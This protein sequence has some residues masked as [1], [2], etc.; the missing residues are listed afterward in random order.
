[1]GG[2]KSEWIYNYRNKKEVGGQSIKRHVKP[3]DEWC[4]EKYM[5]TDYSKIE[6]NDFERKLKEYLVYK[7]LN[8]S[9]EQGKIG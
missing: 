9:E 1:M 2:I 6:K 8:E 7:L 3:E 5:K 4:A